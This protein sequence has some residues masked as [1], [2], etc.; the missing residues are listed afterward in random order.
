MIFYLT[1]YSIFCEKDRYTYTVYDW[2]LMMDD[3]RE[4]YRKNPE[5]ENIINAIGE[6]YLSCQSMEDK[7]GQVTSYNFTRKMLYDVRDYLD[8]NGLDTF[9]LKRIHKGHDL[10]DYIFDILFKIEP[11][12][13]NLSYKEYMRMKKG[14]IWKEHVK[15]ALN[16]VAEYEYFPRK[17]IEY[18][19]KLIM[20]K[21]VSEVKNIHEVIT[22]AISPMLCP[23]L[24]EDGTTED[25]EAPNYRKRDF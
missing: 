18:T 16:K 17:T 21:D 14:P 11:V 1:R 15:R 2:I 4:I 10:T 25:N 19:K 7:Y 9:A 6:R 23:F 24:N 3:Y 12:D 8:I 5:K 22:W 13:E 20:I